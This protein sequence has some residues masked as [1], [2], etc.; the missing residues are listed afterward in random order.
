MMRPS[1]TMG[2]V[3]INIRIPE[4]IDADF[5]KN[6]RS[7]FSASISSEIALIVFFRTKK[8]MHCRSSFEIGTPFESTRAKAA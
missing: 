7:A 1:A 6:S 4:S 3:P 5:V 8:K 2:T